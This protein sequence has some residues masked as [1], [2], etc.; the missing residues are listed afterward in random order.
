MGK[1]L[2]KRPS[3]KE[4]THRT[5]Q[6]QEP[7]KASC[8]EVAARQQGPSSEEDPAGRELKRCCPCHLQSLAMALHAEPH[9]K[10]GVQAVPGHGLRMLHCS[11][12]GRQQEL[13]QP[14]IWVTQPLG[15][16]RQVSVC[17]GPC[18][19]LSRF[20]TQ[21]SPGWAPK[22][23]RPMPPL[24]GK[25]PRAHSNLLPRCSPLA[26]ILYKTPG[27]G[28]WHHRLDLTCELTEN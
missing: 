10:P 2:I 4:K 16:S 6:C 11:R 24:G 7:W 8:V 17:A 18:V 12:V 28:S 26:L 3:R 1:G 15:Y 9:Q 23:Q 27:Q 22:P 21:K 19:Q 20:S 5:A 13:I 14:A 25:C